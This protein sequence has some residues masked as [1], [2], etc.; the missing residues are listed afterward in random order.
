M[1]KVIFLLVVCA[2]ACDVVAAVLPDMKF[3]TLDTRDGLSNSQVN[4]I[5]KD[6]RGFVWIGT[7]YGLNRYD[8]YRVRT[9]YSD[10]NDTTTMRSNYVSDIFE[11][12]DGCLWLRQGM[13]F[14]LYDPRTERFERDITVR[15][16]KFGII[17]GIDRFYI[18]KKKNYWV[19]TYDE[20]L[21]Y[22]NPKTRKLSLFRYG[23]DDDELPGDFWV[24]SFA[25]T[26]EGVVLAS[27]KG[28]LICFDGERGKVRWRDDFCRTHG[29]RENVDYIVR[30]DADNNFF[31]VS[32]GTTFFHN[33]KTGHWCCSLAEYLRE[34]QVEGVPD[35][36]IIW[37]VCKDAKGWLWVSTD[38]MGLF[39]IDLKNRLARQY[40][41]D[42]NDDTTLPEMTLRRLYCDAD[43]KMWISSYKSGLCLYA[44][45]MSN[46]RTI[47]LGDVTTMTEDHDGRYWIGTNDSGILRYD[48]HTGESTPFNTSNAGFKS[49]AV[50]ASLT[51]RDGSLWFGT[52]NGGLLHYAD[53]KWTNYL[54]TG[55][56]T[57]L[58]TNN[59][60][61]LEE[62]R[63]GNVWIGTLGRGIQKLDRR[64]GR[65]Y[66]YTTKNTPLRSSYMTSLSWIKKGWLLVG[67]SEYYALLNPVTGKVIP[68]AIPSVAGLSDAMA[69]S[70]D[71]VE[72]SRGLIWYGS[73]SGCCVYDERTKNRWMLDMKSGLY[74]SSVV[75]IE[76][77]R[78]HTMWVVTE[79][80]IS[81]I[82]PERQENGQ[83][84]FTIRS[85]NNHDGVQQGPFNQRAIFCTRDGQILIGG[86]YGLD[87]I[88]PHLSSEDRE[89]ERPVFSGLVLFGEELC[90]G[91]EYEGHVILDE[92]LDVCR[93]I[94]LRYSE[95]QFTIQL[96]STSGEVRNPARFVY[97]L[98]GFSDKWIKTEQVNPNI[99]YMSLPSGS[100]TLCVRMLNDDG[101]MGE[102]ESR[103]EIVIRPPFY[104][105][106]WAIMCYVLLAVGLAWW[107][108]RDFLRNH[109][110]RMSQPASPDEAEA[111]L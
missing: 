30:V 76:E 41:H 84:N 108:R 6:S 111:I 49:D 48:P 1:K 61:S 33:R 27:S 106:W 18:D 39:V 70:T 75:S 24:S 90:A 3:R 21:Y 16:R 32:I 100:Y 96:G 53:G 47:D 102:E 10:T 25:T 20:G 57:Q 95:N 82:V 37:D 19:K 107:W 69:A 60:W 78:Q 15:L 79:H 38:H 67:C 44:K 110:E 59:V 104:R 7:A 63:W 52:Y 89:K 80:G 94:V 103:L 87:I 73:A 51:T 17:G 66:N 43:G 40:V 13:G 14:C 99:T 31:V 68:R 11:D 34:H 105:T 28:D 81:N 109:P 92:A 72:D 45:R 35:N 8:G 54:A 93:R 50:M 9:Y 62:D 85:Y 91:E 65:F 98:E 58:A 22:Y 12:S 26:D 56:T 29:G 86:A 83:W 2:I 77:D 55:D 42:K 71:V 74:G 64:T 5:Y 46:F 101:S 23:Y 97:K 4:C 36:L 88:N